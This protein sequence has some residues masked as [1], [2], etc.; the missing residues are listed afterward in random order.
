MTGTR[1]TMMSWAR[2]IDSFEAVPETYKQTYQMLVGNAGTIPY[3][4]LAPAQGNFRSHKS[5]E[6]LLC[7][8]D[9]TFY[10]LEPDGSQVVLTGYGYQDINS[11]EL[12]NILLYSWFSFSG[13]TDTGA[14]AALT[15]AFNEATLRHFTPFLSKM[16]PAPASHDQFDLKAEQSKLDHLSVEN[17]KFMNF[18]REGLVRGEKVILSLYQ[19]PIRQRM[20][21]VLGRSVYHT[22]SLAHLTVLT[23]KEVMLFGEA[24]HVAESK[25]GKYGGVRRFLPLSGLDSVKLEQ[26]PDDMLSLTFHISPEIAVKR[27]FN[28][29]HAREVETL[30]K[31]VEGLMGYKHQ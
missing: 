19:P 6:R 22:H 21:T 3:T 27:L 9:N 15:V 11:F 31:A 23:D 20:L 28:A 1:Q 8:I 24:E 5:I 17:F 18:A 14:D 12:G 26:E 7:E 13:K 4:V 25:R 29:S 30:K 2:P 16:R 10:A